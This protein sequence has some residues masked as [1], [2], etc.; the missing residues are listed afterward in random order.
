MTRPVYKNPLSPQGRG[1]GEGVLI[2][3]V[4]LDRGTPSPQPS[5]PGGEGEVE[6]VAT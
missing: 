2:R 4:A 5:P 6:A 1:Q 3:R